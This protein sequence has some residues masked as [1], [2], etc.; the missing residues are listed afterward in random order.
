MAELRAVDI[1]P[2]ELASRVLLGAHEQLYALHDRVARL[3]RQ[4]R[5]NIE[6]ARLWVDRQHLN[7]DQVM[8][9]VVLTLYGLVTVA[10]AWAYRRKGR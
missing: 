9:I 10:E 8:Q 7:P 2:I 6:R 3:D 5:H 4:T 1:V